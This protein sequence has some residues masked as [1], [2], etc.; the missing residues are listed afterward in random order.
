MR[1][2]EIRLELGETIDFHIHYHPYLVVSLGGGEN[3]IETIFGRKIS[4][5]EPI[6]SF[7]IIN[8]MREVHRPHQQG[9]YSVFLPPNRAQIGHSGS[10]RARSQARPAIQTLS[11]YRYEVKMVKLPEGAPEPSTRSWF[12][13]RM[14]R[15]AK[16]RSKEH[17]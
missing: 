12:N 9:W 15:G 7:V 5:Q 11:P 10:P 4:T 13:R 16:N 6:G 17:P 1:I 3:E 2:W 14:C 8:E